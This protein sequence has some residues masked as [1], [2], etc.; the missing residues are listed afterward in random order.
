MSSESNSEHADVRYYVVCNHEEQYS[1]WR[2]DK[3]V[4]VGWQIVGDAETKAQCLARIAEIWTDMR[5]ASL[6]KNMD[7]QAGATK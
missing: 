2:A 5:P 7:Q 1:I 4:P 6:R 3:T